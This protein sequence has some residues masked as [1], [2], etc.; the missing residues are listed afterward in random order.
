MSV[1]RNTKLVIIAFAL[2][3][4][5][6]LGLNYMATQDDSRD[7]AWLFWIGLLLLLALLVWLWMRRDDADSIR[8]DAQRRAEE[9]A[10]SAKQL[11]EKTTQPVDFQKIAEEAKATKSVEKPK[12]QPTQE[13]IDAKVAGAER[14]YKEDDADDVDAP[15]STSDEAVATATVGVGEAEAEDTP[16]EEPVVDTPAPVEETEA[17]APAPKKQASSK[18]VKW[19]VKGQDN[20]KLVEGI[21]PK[22]EK[23]LQA[24]GIDTFE[25]LS[26]SDEETIRAAIKAAGMRFAPSVPT[27]AEQASY[28]AKQDMDG[29]QAF[30]D[31]LTAGRPPKK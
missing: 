2:V 14:K 13:E 27:W 21:G 24:A 5:V 12:P 4:A 19:Q 11:A 17:K 31:S 1:N 9:A 29:L 7:E 20:L 25:K 30:Q 15:A 16:A 23:A 3:G 28:A 18:K 6:L 10:E 22:M 8:T 26:Q